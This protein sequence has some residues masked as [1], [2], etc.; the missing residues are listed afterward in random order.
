MTLVLWCL[1]LGGNN[2]DMALVSPSTSDKKK[3]RKISALIMMTM[4]KSGRLVTINR[5]AGL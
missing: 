2:V 3:D 4:L 1:C 5:A